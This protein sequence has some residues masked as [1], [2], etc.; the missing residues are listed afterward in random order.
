MRNRKV[1]NI[2]SSYSCNQREGIIKRKSRVKRRG[3]SGTRRRRGRRCEWERLRSFLSTLRTLLEFVELN[4]LSLW[5]YYNPN[6]IP[7]L[8]PNWFQNSNSIFYDL[9][10]N[11]CICL[12]SMFDIV[13]I[14]VTYARCTVYIISYVR[15]YIHTV[16]AVPC[17]CLPYECVITL[18]NGVVCVALSTMWLMKTRRIKAARHWWFRICIC[19]VWSFAS[20]YRAQY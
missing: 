3:C 13:N 9:F 20:R 18:S 1:I 16:A 5:V 2:I 11:L 19:W 4:P 17:V 12:C 7:C 10:F 6:H 8:S 15:I 14:Y